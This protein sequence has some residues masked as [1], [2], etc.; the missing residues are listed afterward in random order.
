[1][2]IKSFTFTLLA[3]YLGTFLR[4]IIDNNFIISIIGS[5]FLGYVISKRLSELSKKILLIG[6]FSSFTS[7]SGY[8]YFLYRII[9]E[10]DIMEFIIFSNVFIIINLLSMFF[11]L[12]ISRKIT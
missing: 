2:K 1:M 9:N 4:L 12:W 8:I 7:F 11:G 3:C 6:F 10:G 5:F